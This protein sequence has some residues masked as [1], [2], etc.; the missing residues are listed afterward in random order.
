MFAALQLE[1]GID[2]A[3]YSSYQSAKTGEWDIEKLESDLCIFQLRP[4]RLELYK[5]KVTCANTSKK[6]ARPKRKRSEPKKFD[7]ETD[8]ANDR[9]RN[10]CM[11]EQDISSELASEPSTNRPQRCKCGSTTHQRISHKDCSFN[12]GSQA[13]VPQKTRHCTQEAS[14]DTDY[15]ASCSQHQTDDK[16]HTTHAKPQKSILT[17]PVRCT[18]APPS[19]RRKKSRTVQL[20]GSSD[21]FKSQEYSF[22]FFENSLEYEHQMLKNMR[23]LMN[24]VRGE[25]HDISFGVLQQ[26]SSGACSLS[27]AIKRGEDALAVYYTRGETVYIVYIFVPNRLRGQ[28]KGRELVML[29]KQMAIAEGAQQ[30]KVTLQACI[31]QAAPFYKALGFLSST[32]C[33]RKKLYKQ[34]YGSGDELT[35]F[36]SERRP[37]RGSTAKSE[38]PLVGS[39]VGSKSEEASSNGSS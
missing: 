27:T 35:L 3:E 2:Y 36:I 16:S 5:K 9:T 15:E 8:G 20:E 33:H 28:G 11:G 23:N 13:S 37:V 7:P 12:N 29:I 38:Q 4:P 26:V 1:C 30:L 25:T 14:T 10:A 34:D 6:E 18:A 19:K 39:M 31:A 24:G 17:Q 22:D 32:Q 21:S